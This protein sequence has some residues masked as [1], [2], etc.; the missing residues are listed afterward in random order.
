MLPAEVT[1][2]ATPEV[3]DTTDRPLPARRPDRPAARV[4]PEAFLSVTEWAALSARSNWIGLALVAHCWAVIGAAMAVGVLWPITLPLVIVVVGNRQLGLFVLM[5]EA[6]HG[7]MHPNRRVN[8]TVARWLCRFDLHGYR[9]EHLQHHRYVQ[10]ALNPDLPLSAKFP[11]SPESLR[12]KFIRDLTGQTFYQQRFAR[13]R[14]ELQARPAGVSRISSW[15]TAGAAELRRQPMFYGGNAAFA[16]LF[17]AFGLCWAWLLMWLLPLA[18]WLML[19]ARIR[20][21]A[22]HALLPQGGSDAFQQARTVTASVLER[23]LIAP[24]RVNFHSEHHLFTQIPCWRL[25]RAHALLRAKGLL[26]RMEIQASYEDVLSRAVATQPA[27]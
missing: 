3:A 14:A 9:A 17:T 20:N 2:A 19:I 10:Q 24:Y 15:I 22:E 6:A 21:I 23:I 1:P 11:V 26:P 8:D 16:A 13:L 27:R 4:R 7:L 25:P 5:H 18:T 12:R